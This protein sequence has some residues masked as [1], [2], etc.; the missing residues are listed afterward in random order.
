[1][2]PGCVGVHLTADGSL[3]LVDFLGSA[4]S[5]TLIAAVLDKMRYTRAQVLAFVDAAHTD[6][7]ANSSNRRGVIFLD[8]YLRPVGQNAMDRRAQTR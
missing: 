8:Y 4:L 3:S 1:M 2:I 5:R 6:V 7:E